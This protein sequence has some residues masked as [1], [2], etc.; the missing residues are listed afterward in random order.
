M[1]ILTRYSPN[2]EEILMSSSN[3]KALV[4][5]HKINGRYE[6]CTEEESDEK[7][8]DGETHETIEKIPSLDS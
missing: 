5:W 3:R 4:E 1:F 2:S 7:Y 6:L 8:E